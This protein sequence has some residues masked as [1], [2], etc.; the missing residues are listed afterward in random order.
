[1]IM[2][3]I[4]FPVTLLA[5]VWGWD[6]FL[7]AFCLANITKRFRHISHSYS[8]TYVAL[9][10]SRPGARGQYFFGRALQI[11]NLIFLYTFFSQPTLTVSFH[12]VFEFYWPGQQRSMTCRCRSRKVCCK[13]LTSQGLASPRQSWSVQL[14]IWFRFAQAKHCPKV[15]PTSPQK[16]RQISEFVCNFY[17]DEC[18]L[19]ELK[20]IHIKTCEPITFMK[21]PNP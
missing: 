6:S 14:F 20:N 21:C 2:Y 3:R 8:I 5:G 16:E 11:S 13:Y 17:A 15:C 7:A 19:A 10:P 12:F 18:V 9:L 1:M 4:H